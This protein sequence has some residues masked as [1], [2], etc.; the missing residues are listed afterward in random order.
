M[1]LALPN[2]S[3]W[4]VLLVSLSVA[5]AA[6]SSEP[7]PRQVVKSLESM[8]KS[9]SGEGHRDSDAYHHLQLLVEL[10]KGETKPLRGVSDDDLLEAK[11]Q[12]I[13]FESA[14]QKQSER[15]RQRRAKRD[16]IKKA[17][18]LR[19]AISAV[20][21][22]LRLRKASA[23]ET[24]HD[25]PQADAVACAS[26]PDCVPPAGNDEQATLQF[27]QCVR[28]RR[29]NGM[30]PNSGASEHQLETL[31]EKSLLP[32]PIPAL[33]ITWP[34]STFFDVDKD[35]I[36]SEATA[37][38]SFLA[39]AI[40]HDIEDL[41]LYV[42]GHT[43]DTGTRQYN[44][45]LSE[46]R[47]QDVSRRLVALGVP[48]QRIT[49][50]GLGELQPVAN[51]D[52]PDGQAANRRVEFM[53]S[54]YKQANHKLIEDRPIDLNFIRPDEERIQV[55]PRPREDRL[56]ILPPVETT[57]SSSMTQRDW[58]QATIGNPGS[59]QWI[60]FLTERSAF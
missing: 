3:Q 31:E 47:A 1:A 24:P 18:H 10:V 16:S 27:E 58:K 53:L 9:L 43:D 19:Y 11:E 45:D 21:R 2:Q 28:V 54:S 38:L 52:T 4:L 42:L 35:Q 50:R 7:N 55:K 8:Q 6:I 32:Y 17:T 14:F 22:E 30:S 40:S 51:N 29:L 60:R 46:R 48:H 26:H 56:R 25:P 23:P 15:E 59:Q 20:E 39:D 13:R 36:R 44:Q 57:Q 37:V 41:H 49:S 33:R 5:S 12:A 34:D